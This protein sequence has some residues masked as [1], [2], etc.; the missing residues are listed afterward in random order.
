MLLGR[1]VIGS[2]AFRVNI[3]LRRSDPT[4]NPDLRLGLTTHLEQSTPGVAQKTRLLVVTPDILILLM[5][6][7]QM[8]LKIL[9]E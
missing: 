2:A 3:T 7:R 9:S 5:N 4:A 8:H 1:S 6:V